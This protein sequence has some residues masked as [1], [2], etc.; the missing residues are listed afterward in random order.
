MNTVIAEKAVIGIMLAFPDMQA[1]AFK[2][3]NANDE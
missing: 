1:D 3:L 2:S